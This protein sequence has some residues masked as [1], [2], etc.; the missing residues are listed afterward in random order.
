M[1]EKGNVKWGKGSGLG[2]PLLKERPTEACA[3]RGEARTTFGVG[4]VEFREDV[5]WSWF[6]A[7]I[8]DRGLAEACRLAQRPGY[9]GV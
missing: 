4:G 7:F 8:G 2:V 9:G 1:G 5:R 3:R 6:V